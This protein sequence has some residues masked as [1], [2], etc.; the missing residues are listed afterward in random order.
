MGM[1][2]TTEM[3]LPSSVEA[4]GG[5]HRFNYLGMHR[6]LVTLPSLKTASIFSRREIVLGVLDALRE[7]SWNQHFDVYAYSFLPDHL[8]LIIR[9]KDETSDMKLFLAAFRQLSS[10][11]LQD[12]LGHPLW[13]KKYT[14]RVLRK[15][16]ETKAIAR[17]IFQ[18][19]VRAGF[20]RSAA[21]YE[22]QGSFVTNVTKTLSGPITPRGKDRNRNFQSPRVAQDHRRRFQK[23]NREK[24]KP[25]A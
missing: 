24:G 6:Y 17:E 5:S 10:M 23:G 2:T 14:E 15:S 11:R 20:A 7:A 16:E 9:G 22:F 12:T 8:T 25:G 13:K 4:R 1:A 3:H 21:E 18:A 19:P